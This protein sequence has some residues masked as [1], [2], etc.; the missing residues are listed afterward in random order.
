MK[1][2]TRYFVYGESSIYK[3]ISPGRIYWYD[4]VDHLWE[5]QRE[6]WGDLTYT[7]LLADATGCLEQIVGCT[8]YS[9]EDIM[10]L[11]L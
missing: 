8:E 2:K 3:V 5:Y 4:A 6:D 11:L 10:L 1:F 9:E 7:D